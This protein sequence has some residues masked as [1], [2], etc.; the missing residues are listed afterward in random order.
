MKIADL[1]QKARNVINPPYNTYDIFALA[2]VVIILLTIPF[3]VISLQQRNVFTASADV[4]SLVRLINQYRNSKGLPSLYEDKYLMNASCWMAGDMAAKNYFSHTDS[5]GRTW[6]KRLTAF[7]VGTSYWRGENLAAGASTGLSVLNLWKNSPGHN[8]VLLNPNFRRIGVGVAYNINST[9]DW[10]WAA[11]FASGAAT[12][13]AQCNLVRVQGYKVVM[14]GNKNVSPAAGQ[15]VTLDGRSSTTTNPYYFRYLLPARHSVSVTT[16]S[17]GWKVGYTLCYNRTDCHGK[18][19]TVGTSVLLDIPEGGYAD[20]WWHYTPA[21]FL[22]RVWR[23]DDGDGRWD[24]LNGDRWWDP[25]DEPFIRV[26]GTA[27]SNG[28]DVSGVS[29]SYSGASSGA[30]AANLC[31]PD[32]YYSMNPSVAGT[33]TVRVVPP[34][35][36]IITGVY[37]S[38]TTDPVWTVNSDRSITGNLTAGL[39]K[40]IWFGIKPR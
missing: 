38:D 5:L 31:N 2:G 34:S 27:C 37:Q 21:R 28:V 15:R 20:L 13:A 8:A 18:S 9:Y 40:D 11:D 26:P 22:G 36:W 17:S 23:D 19:P 29:V 1:F 33:Y 7:G 35:G 10:Y 24:D 3:T 6:D 16:P 4:D 14:P 12:A 39:S 30:A 25:G 32:P